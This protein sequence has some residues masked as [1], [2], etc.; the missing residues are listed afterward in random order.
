M[1]NSH[2]RIYNPLECAVF[3]KVKEEHGGNSNMAPGFPLVVNDTAIRTSEALYQALRFP[4]KVELQRKII[5]E[6]SPM[7]AKM[8]GKP[9]RAEFCRPDWE[10]LQVTIMRWCLRVKLLQNWQKFSAVL[11]ATGNLPIVELSTKGDVFWGTVKIKEL[12][13]QKGKGK[14]QPKPPK[15]PPSEQMPVGFLVGYNVMGRLNQELREN[16]KSGTDRM[17]QDFSIL[18]PLLIDDFLLFGKPIKPIFRR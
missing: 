15:Y 12:P 10:Q 6:K 14:Y 17:S 2:L 1:N 3:C 4:L 8:V 18:N 9:F 16:L 5:A 11:L 7:T 13:E